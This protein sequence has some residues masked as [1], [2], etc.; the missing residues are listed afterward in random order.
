MPQIRLEDGRSVPYEIRVSRRSRR[1]RLTINARDGLVLVTPPGVGREWLE[2][3]ASSWHR[4]VARQLDTL[5]IPDQQTREAQATLPERVE[6]GAAGETWELVYRYVPRSPARVR[7]SRGGLLLLSGDCADT[8]A[9]KNALR[10]WLLRRAREL[11]PP[12]LA[13]ISGETGLEYRKLGIRSQRSRWGSCSAQ[14]DITLNCQLLF[15]PPRL[16]RHVMLHELCHTQVL[17][18]SPRF[19]RTVARFEPELE[20]LRR[21]MRRSWSYVPEWAMA[22]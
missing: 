4:W 5:A 20:E 21:D 16:A 7:E 11:L 13:E 12:W 14:G 22:R 1:V 2:E 19:W 3:L 10:R 9:C 8:D 17:N 6:L 15:L 18:H